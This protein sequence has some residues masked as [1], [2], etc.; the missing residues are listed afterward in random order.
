MC[1][2][3]VIYKHNLLIAWVDYAKAY[4]TT[5]FALILRHAAFLIIVS[6]I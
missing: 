5:S 6:L 2:D 1:H 4:D 3:A